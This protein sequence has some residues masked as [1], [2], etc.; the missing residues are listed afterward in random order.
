MS[1]REKAIFVPFIVMTLWLGIYPAAVTDII[2]PSVAALVGQVDGA[3]A[4]H[5]AAQTGAP[6]VRLAGQF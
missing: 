4:A 3:L 1:R 6:G 2:G 5:E